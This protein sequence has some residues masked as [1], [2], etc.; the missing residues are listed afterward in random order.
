MPAYGHCRSLRK[1]QEC[2]VHIAIRI[3][4]HIVP[5]ILGQHPVL[6]HQTTEVM[7]ACTSYS[8]K[9]YHTFTTEKSRVGSVT[10][11]CVYQKL[12]PLSKGEDQCSKISS[13]ITQPAAACYAFKI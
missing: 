12:V 3:V 5:Q 9:L 2:A 13:L 10:T 11:V 6:Y 7:V 4:L 1:A 8:P